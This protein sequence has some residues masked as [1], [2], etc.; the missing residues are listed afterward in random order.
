MLTHKVVLEGISV[1]PCCLYTNAQR[2]RTMAFQGRRSVPRISCFDGLGRP[3]YNL[4][5]IT[6][7]GKILF[8]R[9]AKRSKARLF[10]AAGNREHPCSN[11]STP[12][13]RYFLVQRNMSG[14]GGLWKLER[15]RRSTRNVPFSAVSGI[16]THSRGYSDR[17]SGNLSRIGAEKAPGVSP[18]FLDK[19]K[20]LGYLKLMQGGDAWRGTRVC[21]IGVAFS[22][23]PTTPIATESVYC[24]NRRIARRFRRQ[25]CRTG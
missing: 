16:G 3:S 23:L 21:Q 9:P 12:Y 15:Y 20:Q 5:N 6:S 7:F 11:I 1:R 13:R 22:S 10:S 25:P 18:A 2:Q 4:R 19:S 24:V 14:S 17:M 8:S